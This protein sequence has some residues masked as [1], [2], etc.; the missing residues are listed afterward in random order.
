MNYEIPL[1]KWLNFNDPKYYQIR[2]KI[3]S[4]F[5]KR[6]FKHFTVGGIL[7]FAIFITLFVVKGYFAKKYV[8]W[9]GFLS[10][11]PLILCFT[12]GIR[13][14]FWTF[15]VGISFE[16]GTSFLHIHA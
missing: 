4:L 3:V 9:S 2:W 6:V 15:F 7:L 10:A 11:I 16:K 1:T 5:H 12:F 8:K 13:N 14:S